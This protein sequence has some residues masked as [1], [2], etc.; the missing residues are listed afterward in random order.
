MIWEWGEFRVSE[1]DVRWKLAL[2]GGQVRKSYEE[3]NESEAVTVK[4][5]KNEKEHSLEFCQ[6]SRAPQVGLS[7]LATK[8]FRLIISLFQHVL[9]QLALTRSIYK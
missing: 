7:T 5:R 1:Y 2:H 6:G 3:T 8:S 9:V 4:Q